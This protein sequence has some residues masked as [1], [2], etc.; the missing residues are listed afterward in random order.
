M[1]LQASVLDRVH[2]E[3]FYHH[4]NF[5]WAVLPNKTSHFV[6]MQTKDP[7]VNCLIKDTEPAKVQLKTSY[8]IS[9]LPFIAQ[10]TVF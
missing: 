3:H 5:C 9:R 1:G 2:I 8:H 6:T 4:R 7:E 10:L